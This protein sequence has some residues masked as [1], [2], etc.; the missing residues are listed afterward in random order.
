MPSQPMHQPQPPNLTLF[1]SAAN[2]QGK[3]TTPL[4]HIG[5]APHALQSAMLHLTRQ[6]QEQS[7]IVLPQN[8]FNQG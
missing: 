6:T 4:T 7:G 8:H 1:G 3:V 2:L 5:I